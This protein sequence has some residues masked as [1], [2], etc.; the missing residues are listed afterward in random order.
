MFQLQNWAG[1]S[2]K[3]KFVVQYLKYKQSPFSKSKFLSLW[4][5]NFHQNSNFSHS[6]IG[7]ILAK[8]VEMPILSNCLEFEPCN[9]R[10][11]HKIFKL[12]NHWENI[13]HI[14]LV[15]IYNSYFSL[16][17]IF[18]GYFMGFSKVPQLISNC[19]HIRML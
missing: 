11:K 8:I 9:K 5:S 18:H 19:S 10:K 12:V 7:R 16:S 3:E 6:K 17:L 1:L 14:F 13:Y 15:E 4:N 2:F